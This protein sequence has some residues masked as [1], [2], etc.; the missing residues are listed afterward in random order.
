MELRNGYSLYRLDGDET[1]FCLGVFKS[2]PVAEAALTAIDQPYRE[3]FI[4]DADCETPD[5]YID[6]IFVRPRFHM[7]KG[8]MRQV[9]RYLLSIPPGEL[10]S[11]GW[12][13]PLRGMGG[14]RTVSEYILKHPEDL[15]KGSGALFLANL[16]EDLGSEG[17]KRATMDLWLQWERLGLTNFILH[18]IDDPTWVGVTLMEHAI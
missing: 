18:Q 1:R 4:I 16:R 9:G 3:Q 5:D 8:E 6:E 15:E 7:T 17:L 13:G 10:L 2:M 12:E 11:W 14:F